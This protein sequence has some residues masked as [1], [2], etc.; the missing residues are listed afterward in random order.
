MGS[1]TTI[2]ALLATCTRLA[3]TI[4]YATLAMLRK[5][6]AGAADK[7]LYRGCLWQLA[8]LHIANTNQRLLHV[9]VQTMERLKVSGCLAYTTKCN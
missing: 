2:V 9:G 1:A 3:G 6:G 8:S 5:G 4:T 7:T